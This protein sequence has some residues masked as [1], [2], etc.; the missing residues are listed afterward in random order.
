MSQGEKKRPPGLGTS[1][2]FQMVSA[3]LREALVPQPPETLYHYT[4]QQG[5]LGILENKEIWATHTQYVNDEME[6]QL[7][8]KLIVEE[9]KEQMKAAVDTEKNILSD[10]LSG[11]EGGMHTANVCVCSFS[12]ER[13]SLSQFRAY[14]GSTGGYAIGFDG[15]FLKKIAD[16]EQSYLVRCVYEDDC[17][18][19]FVR[20]FVTVILRWNKK[21]LN[22]GHYPRPLR[23]GHLPSSL[24][25]CAPILKHPSFKH[26]NEWR[27]VSRLLDGPKERRKKRFGHRPG[28]SM[29]IPFYRIRLSDRNARMQIKE[30]VIG[31]TPHKEQSLLSIEGLLGDYG[32]DMTEVG[33]D[34]S[35]APYRDW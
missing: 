9:I 26:E 17:Q 30:I 7:A 15:G 14:G 3:I 6:F 35:K 33:V 4:D 32:Y 25:Q 8:E 23:G 10:M 2:P 16:R 5:L 11:A 12:Q 31:P 34:L 18:R 20:A 24:L 27:I 28:K 29:V 22:S 13:D 1:R 19:E 21:S